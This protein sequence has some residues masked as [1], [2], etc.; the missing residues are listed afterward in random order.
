MN[1]FSNHTWFGEFFFPEDHENRFAGRLDYSPSAGIRLSWLMA[2]VVPP[3]TSEILHGLLENGDACTLFGKFNTTH[4]GLSIK[5]GYATKNGTSYF[6]LAAIGDLLSNE[7]ISKDVDFSLSGMD[8]FFVPSGLKDEATYRNESLFSWKTP[9]AKF[10]VGLNARFK[11]IGADITSRIYSHDESANSCLRKAYNEI[12]KN[13]PSAYFMHR[14][15]LTYRI[16]I[17]TT[18]KASY[19]KLYDHI[20][21]MA[22]LFSIL[23]NAPVHPEEIVAHVGEDGEPMPSKVY[24]LPSLMLD[25]RTIELAKKERSHFN[26]PLT[27]S[28]VDLEK[29]AKKW[30]EMP[31]RNSVMISSI[32]HETGIRTEHSAHGDV[33]LYATQLE[34]ISHADGQKSEKYLYPIRRYGGTILQ[35]ALLA[36][37]QKYGLSDIGK[38]VSDVRNEIAHVGRPKKITAQMS[39]RDLVDMSRILQLAALGQMLHE[40]GISMEN[41]SKYMHIFCP[42]VLKND[43]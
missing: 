30:L 28:T 4:S 26:M 20:S 43:G 5:Q 11:S 2:G 17:S 42:R 25:S 8:E 27:N 34:A 18:E 7:T 39:L 19:L 9:Q 41:I 23:V 35:T 16:H 10:E 15:K 33:V 22:N 40:I 21:A 37:A 29:T 38:L 6:S 36:I 1:I 31:R 13:N 24:L 14:E 3:R 32:Q 12:C